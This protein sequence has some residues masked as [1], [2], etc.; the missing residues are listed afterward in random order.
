MK[1]KGRPIVSSG[2]LKHGTTEGAGE[3]NLQQL[4]VLAGNR[5]T[6]GEKEEALRRS[7]LRH[8]KKGASRSRPALLYSWMSTK[9]EKKKKERNVRVQIPCRRDGEIPIQRWGRAICIE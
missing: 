3:R 1:E 6:G 7:Y 5:T 9:K 8:R 2:E 4:A